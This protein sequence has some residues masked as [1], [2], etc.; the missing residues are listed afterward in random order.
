MPLDLRLAIGV[1]LSTFGTILVI[2]GA[3]EHAM[4]LGVNV[5]LWWGG[6]MLGCG[7]GLLTFVYARRNR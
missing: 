4:V 7:L 2:E 3:V 6:A 1:L 5:N